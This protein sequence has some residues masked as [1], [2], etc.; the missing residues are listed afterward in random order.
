MRTFGLSQEDAQIGNKLRDKSKGSGCL[1][2]TAAEVALD[3][4]AVFCRKFDWSG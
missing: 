3:H 1:R 4:A 2:V